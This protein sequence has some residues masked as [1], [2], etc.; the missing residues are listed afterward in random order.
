MR[1]KVIHFPGWT[2]RTVTVHLHKR[3][4]FNPFLFNVRVGPLEPAVLDQQASSD[5]GGFVFVSPIDDDRPRVQ[6]HSL[7]AVPPPS[8]SQRSSLVASVSETSGLPS[9]LFS[10]FLALLLWTCGGKKTFIGLLVS[11]CLDI[12]NKKN[13]GNALV[14]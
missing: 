3:V 12:L 14:M 13:K 11:V 10:V 2:E 8:T 4:N 5:D 9:A 6:H 7:L 1:R